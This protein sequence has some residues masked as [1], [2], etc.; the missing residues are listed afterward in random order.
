MRNLTKLLF[1]SSFFIV[2]IGAAAQEYKSSQYLGYIPYEYPLK[3]N[4]SNNCD[5]AIF[6]TIDGTCNNISDPDKAEWGATHTPTFRL[7]PPV[8][9]DADPMNA[10]TGENRKS[11]RA[12]SNL[13]CDQNEDTESWDSLSSFVFTWGQ[14]IDHDI[15]LTPETETDLAPISMPDDEPIFTVDMPFFRSEVF[16]NTGINTPR[17]QMNINTAFIDG[18]MV[19]GSDII[20]ADWLRSFVDGKLKSSAGNF[21][22]YNT[23]DGEFGSP[24]DPDTPSMFG[25]EEGDFVFVAGDVRA[26]EQPSLLSMHTLFMREHNRIC[27]ELLLAGMTDDELIYQTARKKVGALIQN[28]TYQEFLPALK[29]SL[30]T[31]N[32]YDT[33]VQ[34]DI[35]SIFS[36]AAYRFG[37]TVVTDTF[38]MVDNNCETMAVGNMPIMEGFFDPAEVADYGVEPFLKG[39]SMERQQEFDNFVIDALRNMLFTNTPV[40]TFGFDLVALN[41]QRGRDHGLP[42][43]NSIRGVFNGPV[44]NDFSDI[45][46]NS[47]LVAN[48]S[49][50]YD[51]NINEIDAWVG[52]MCEDKLPGKIMGETNHNIV[53]DQFTRLRDGDR[54]YFEHDPFYAAS[55]IA[56]IQTTL[57]SDIILRNTTIEMLPE[58][59][60]HASSCRKMVTCED[61]ENNQALYRQGALYAS[62][63]FN[64][65]GNEVYTWYNDE[66]GEMVAQ[67]TGNGF[68]SPTV[69]GSF[70]LVVTDPD[71]PDCE[72][73]FGPRDISTLDGCCDFE[74]EE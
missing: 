3:T 74:N 24:L 60:F 21:L 59:V 15:T 4:G 27:D 40:S 13:V 58:D 57:L 67:F 45:A 10:M 32:G 55:E 65:D 8:Y 35:A 25:D 39:M 19:Y 63:S 66:T 28:I 62:P 52:L 53:A 16:P 50:A 68:Y 61:I 54:F 42:D 51:G 71:L 49:E 22:P 43:Y 48:L 38:L 6:R 70:I 31:Y 44:V 73:V 29:I 18:S 26:N 34:P 47:D 9:G 37:H 14:F 23:I 5:N 1:F 64:L 11:P 36:T 33:N 2:S 30:P 69:T 7:M 12:V 41:L 20:R 56:E 46:S 17:A 72:Q